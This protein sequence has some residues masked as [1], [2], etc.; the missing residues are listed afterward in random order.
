MQAKSKQIRDVLGMYQMDPEWTLPSFDGLGKARTEA[1]LSA[2][3]MR[4]DRLQWA[5]QFAAWQEELDDYGVDEAFDMPQAAALNGWDYSPLQRVFQGIITEQGTWDGEEP[6]FADELAQARLNILERRGRWQEYLY[7]AEAEGQTKEYVTMLVRLGRTQEAISYGRQ[8][9]AM[10]EEALALAKALYEHGEH[11]QSLQMAE[12]G[13]TLEGY[14]A[15][16]AKWLREQAM[17]MGEK[18]RALSAAEVA[19]REEISL[20]NY[21]RVAEITGEQWPEC[22]GKLLD[23]IRSK[24]SSY[25]QGIIDV[26]LHEGLLDDAFAALEP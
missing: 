14:K 21:Q 1:V 6:Y 22:R 8:Y 17:L 7:L 26:L 19:F 25:L 15:T 20:E 10:T 2:E 18:A 13:L 5:D 12:H 24:K 16:L 3:L 9:L 23:Y 11:E 4:E